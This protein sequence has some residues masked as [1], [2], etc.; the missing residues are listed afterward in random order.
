M[1]LVG[2]AVVWPG[3]AWGQ[4]RPKR[5]IG[6]LGAGTALEP[7]Q[8]GA[9]R[10]GLA[11]SGYVDGQH[12]TMEFR[13]ARGDYDRLPALAAELVERRVD[14]IAAIAPPAALAAKGAT[15]T[16]SIVFSVGVDPVAAGLVASL[17]RPGGNATGIALLQYALGAKRLEVLLEL[18][19]PG[20]P[21]AMLLNPDS[22]DATPELQEVQAVAQAHGR[23][24]QL[25]RATTAS[26]IEAALAG[27]DR[28]R[29][30]GLL[31]AT[32]PF[33]LSQRRLIVAHAARLRVPTVYPF[34]EFLGEG[35]LVSLG[36]SLPAVRRQAGQYTA[37]IL[38]GVRPA[39]LPVMRPTTFELAVNLKTARALGLTIPPSVL[40]R[41]DDIVE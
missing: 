7:S 24:L 1:G 2:G 12:V 16:I 18:A 29:I 11:E 38:D 21:L 41:A 6:V 26:E 22:P 23:A 31:V 9:F 35:G 36:A 27:L 10:R 4:G 32:D 33:L 3:A 39:E 14:V 28:T 30:G 8:F 25:A 20:T 17:G 34:R 5:V 13:S 40:V 19:P 15:A 37:K